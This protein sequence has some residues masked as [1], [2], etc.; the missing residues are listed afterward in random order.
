MK[1][2]LLLIDRGSKEREAEEELE[3]ICLKVKEGGNYVFPNI[4]F[5]SST[6]L[7]RGWN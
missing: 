1:R 4:V 3:K 5:G 6:T 2:G 7:H